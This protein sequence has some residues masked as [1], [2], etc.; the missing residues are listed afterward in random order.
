M[1]RIQQDLYIKARLEGIKQAQSPIFMVMDSHMEVQH[2][3]FFLL[4]FFFLLQNNDLVL[5]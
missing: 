1:A 4:F 5:I 3:W 2:Q